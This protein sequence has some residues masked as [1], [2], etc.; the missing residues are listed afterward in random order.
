MAADDAVR[1]A[2]RHPFFPDCPRCRSDPWGGTLNTCDA[3]RNELMARAIREQRRVDA[4]NNRLAGGYGGKG[5][6]G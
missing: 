3:H 1:V 6:C 2:K 5:D 4:I